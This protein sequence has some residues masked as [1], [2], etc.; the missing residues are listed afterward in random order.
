M[1]EGGEE[2]NRS[3]EA[4]P[5]KLQ[6]ARQKG[7]VARG[8]D[9]GFFAGLAAFAGFAALAGASLIEQL[10]MMMRRT[11]ATGIPAATDP[12]AVRAVI[13]TSVG[14]SLHGV[15]LMGGTVI[16]VVLLFELVQLRG[17]S[18]STQPLKP[19]FSKL[20]PAKGLKRLF[21]L[22]LLKEAAKSIV[23]LALYTA[24]SVT[25][26]RDAVSDRGAAID[27]ASSLADALRTSG[28]R[29]LWI[30]VLLAFVVAALDQ[31]MA[32][33]EFCKQMRMSRREI[34]R[35]SREREGDPRQK[36]KRRQLHA[37]F[38][39]TA[40]GFGAV[41]GSDM[42]VVNPE[43]YAVALKYERDVGAAPAIVAKGRNLHALAMKRQ[44][45]RA[46]VP[47][48]ARPALARALFARHQIGAE[49]ESDFY[50]EVAELYLLLG[51]SEEPVSR[52]E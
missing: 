22:R 18:F 35:E 23:K 27:D 6:R 26:I 25:V 47:I 17:L 21:S 3:E 44:A 37:Q 14:A 34:T 36:S 28:M 11:L 49:I 51:A 12:Q 52:P 29:L 16:A 30:F 4:T 8:I 50:H 42:L 13:S 48:L 39:R 32:R 45:T 2:Q 19:D 5:F 40:R 1:A 41:A 43:H 7:S 33:R 9:L 38:V 20:N 46:R 31:I 10:A 24:A 15:M